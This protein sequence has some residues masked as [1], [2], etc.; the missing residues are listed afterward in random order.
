MS[1]PEL[2][3][4]QKVCTLLALSLIRHCSGLSSALNIKI[5]SENTTEALSN[6]RGIM[7]HIQ[8]LSELSWRYLSKSLKL[9]ET[10][11]H[12][13]ALLSHYP[14]RFFLQPCSQHS[15]DPT[16]LCT[17]TASVAPSYSPWGIDVDDILW[18][19]LQVSC[20]LSCEEDFEYW[21]LCIDDSILG[22]KH[23]RGLFQLL[24]DGNLY[25]ALLKYF[26]DLHN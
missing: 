20:C 22:W 7:I 13:N 3:C 26:Q 12:K 21:F 1:I 19:A 2:L 6:T 15:T 9:P 14:P 17:A 10:D 11:D 16:L 5:L 24:A 18:S 4:Y 23:S 8:L 25:C